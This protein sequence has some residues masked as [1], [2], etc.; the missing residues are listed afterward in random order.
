MGL[1]RSGA[2]DGYRDD[3]GRTG[4]DPSLLRRSE[5][6]SS[7]SQPQ[8]WSVW[9]HG[10]VRDLSYADSVDGLF[11]IGTVL[12]ISL[13]DETGGGMSLLRALSMLYL[14]FAD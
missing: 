2:W 1:E 9:S 12:S 10:L 4:K 14:F 3:W 8:V 11:A 7:E 6:N 5:V 13:K